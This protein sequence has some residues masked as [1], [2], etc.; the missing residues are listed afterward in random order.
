[1]IAVLPLPNRSYAIPSLG[2]TLFQ[3]NTNYTSTRLTPQGSRR[4]SYVANAGLRH[5]FRQKK[6]AA[7]LTVSDLFNS[8][9]EGSSINTPLLRQEIVR[10]R[11]ARI[12]QVGFTYNFGKAAKKSKDD[13][14]K[15]DNAL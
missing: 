9:K 10:R 12:V 15:F 14:L 13:T 2:D 3:F 1:M 4:P 5:E 8:L 7:V 11:S 6:V